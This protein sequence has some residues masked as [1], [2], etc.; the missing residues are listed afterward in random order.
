MEALAKCLPAV[1]ALLAA[2]ANVNAH[3]E[4]QSY[5]I[6]VRRN[7][8]PLLDQAWAF[9]GFTDGKGFG[10]TDLSCARSR[11]VPV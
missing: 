11:S 6:N 4:W 8:T 7:H 10:A 3:M 1:K 5:R 2:K 9:A